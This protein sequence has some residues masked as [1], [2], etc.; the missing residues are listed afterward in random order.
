MHARSMKTI[1]LTDESY[2]RLKSWKDGPESF[3][4]VVLRLVPKRGLAAEM[5][6]AFEQLPRATDQEKA[7]LDAALSRAIAA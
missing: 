4:S 1:T 5:S 6:A 7:I 3:S 2:D